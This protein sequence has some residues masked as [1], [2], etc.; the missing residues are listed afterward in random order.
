MKSAKAQNALFCLFHML[1]WMRLQWCARAAHSNTSPGRGWHPQEAGR[2]LESVCLYAPLDTL[3][4]RL[5]EA[6]P[7]MRDRIRHLSHRITALRGWVV[8]SWEPETCSMWML[9][10]AWQ[11][12]FRMFPESC[13]TSGS[14]WI[15]FWYVKP[16]GHEKT[17]CQNVSYL[18]RWLRIIGSAP[19]VSNDFV[20]I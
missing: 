15:R 18:Y 8:T 2:S 10:S 17:P 13:S 19:I 20:F 9:W 7:L 5:D 1:R 4:T 3:E 11:W 6:G 16:T 14:N 12:T